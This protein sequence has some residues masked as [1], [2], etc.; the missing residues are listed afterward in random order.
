MNTRLG[1][2]LGVLVAQLLLVVMLLLGGTNTNAETA[3]LSL[4][5]DDVDEIVVQGDESSVTVTRS[6][7]GWQVESLP[8]DSAKVDELV[9][10]FADLSA[11]WPVATSASSAQRFEVA[12]ANY[13]RR[14][15][16]RNNSEDNAV[17][18]L[19]T[20]PGYQRV[21]ARVD[22]SDEVYAVSFSN[23]KAPTKLDDWLDKSLLASEGTPTSIN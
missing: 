8:A 9:N 20:S 11:P 13:Q 2:L 5:A 4:N 18:Y 21:H 7:T 12:D 15:A 16:F 22:G 23:F 3:L 19:G 10:T 6:E 14:I 17:V 1:L